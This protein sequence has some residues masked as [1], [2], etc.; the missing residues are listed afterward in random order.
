MCTCVYIGRTTLESRN[1]GGRKE[2]KTLTPAPY[3]A[4]RD[5]QPHRGDSTVPCFQQALAIRASK[6][7]RKGSIYLRIACD[8][9]TR[10]AFAA[11]QDLQLDRISSSTGFL[12]RQDLQLG[13]IFSSAGSSAR[14]DLQL[15]RIF[16]SR[17]YSSAAELVLG[18][19]VQS[20]ILNS[21]QTSA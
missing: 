20:A 14:Q 16:S 21:T 19:H 6:K 1:Y 3:R 13:R 17:G 2:V 18:S 11:R 9:H 10:T 15:G 8:T 4:K 7:C 5:C 12:A